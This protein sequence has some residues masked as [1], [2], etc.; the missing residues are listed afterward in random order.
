MLKNPVDLRA[1]R[2]EAQLQTTLLCLL[3]RKP[4]HKIT[5][6]ELCRLCPCNRATFYDHYQDIYSLADALE[7]SVVE[8]L[9]ELM[10]RIR[11]CSPDSGAVSALFS[12]FCRN[13]NARC[14]FCCAAKPRRAF[15]KSW[16]TPSSL[17]LKPWYGRTILSR[18][19]TVL[20]SCRPFCAFLPPATTAFSCRSW[21]RTAH[22]DRSCPSWLPAS[23]TNASPAFL[24]EDPAHKPITQ[25]SIHTKSLS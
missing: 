2:T 17:F 15:C 12:S 5:V 23:A 25:N 14:A 6:A 8:H 4:L 9:Q 11:T 22:F 1:R 20:N 21:R 19:N 10:D 13:I 3:E 18:R 7:D 24:L 16:I